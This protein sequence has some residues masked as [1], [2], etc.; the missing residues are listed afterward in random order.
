MDYESLK[1]RV[2]PQSLS[3]PGTWTCGVWLASQEWQNSP[4]EAYF[5]FPKQE[6]IQCPVSSTRERNVVSNKCKTLGMIL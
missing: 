5:V 4:P 3:K 2:S 1:G 6:P